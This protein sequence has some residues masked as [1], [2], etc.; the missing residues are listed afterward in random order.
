MDAK[1]A[2]YGFGEEDFAV[3][4]EIAH[5]QW[6]N[7]QVEASGLGITSENAA[8]AMFDPRKAG[9]EYTTVQFTNGKEKLWVT[10]EPR[11]VILNGSS[12]IA[13]G[14]EGDASPRF[15]DVYEP[16]LDVDGNPVFDKEDKQVKKW[17]GS[18]PY[19]SSKYD[20]PNHIPFGKTLFVVVGNSNELL[21]APII[22]KTGSAATMTMINLYKQSFVPQLIDLYQSVIGKNLPVGQKPTCRFLSRFV[23]EPMLTEGMAGTKKKSSATRAD[24]FKPLT[25]ERFSEIALNP[26]VDK[27][28]VDTI[29]AYVDDILAYVNPLPTPSNVTEE[30]NPPST[31]PQWS[32]PNPAIESSTLPIKP[33]LIAD[34]KEVEASVDEQIRAEYARLDL[35]ADPIRGKA[36]IEKHFGKGITHRTLAFSQK[37]RW[38]DILRE[39]EVLPSI[40]DAVAEVLDDP[41][42]GEPIQPVV[43]PMKD[44][45]AESFVNLVTRVKARVAL[46]KLSQTETRTLL[47]TEFGKSSMSSLEESEMVRYLEIL[48]ELEAK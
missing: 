1:Y 27:E 34:P 38:L 31:E 3:S 39:E 43:I 16:V 17:T 44:M 24:S 26:R 11:I 46:L 14:V 33:Q 42:T 28:T 40:S 45:D 13:N 2:D 5:A 15:M 9:W 47:K 12:I 36:L 8:K 35:K 19:D 21:S 22:L 29:Q 30:N 25:V 18:I 20:D 37:V 41:R 23:F 4:R 7:P 6:L 32:E 10:K 48:N